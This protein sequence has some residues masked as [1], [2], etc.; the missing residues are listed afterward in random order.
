MDKAPG[1]ILREMEDLPTKTSV[2]LYM[3]FPWEDDPF[4]TLE[5]SGPDTRRFYLGASVPN[6]VTQH[7]PWGQDQLPGI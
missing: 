2:P 5:T 1:S 3:V 4:G 7:A 6:S